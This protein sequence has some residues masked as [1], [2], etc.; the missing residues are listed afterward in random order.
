MNWHKQENFPLIYVTLSL[1]IHAR[2]AIYDGHLHV[3]VTCETVK[4][5]YS[6]FPLGDVEMCK[7]NEYTFLHCTH[8]K[9]RH[10]KLLKNVY[11]ILVKSSIRIRFFIVWSGLG[12]DQL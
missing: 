11:S 9:N 8:K 5:I 6:Q 1:R 3:L 4:L 10:V 12:D 2:C 7:R